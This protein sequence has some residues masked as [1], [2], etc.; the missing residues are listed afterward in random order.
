[1]RHEA[2]AARRTPLPSTR[3]GRR[4]HGSGG[5]EEVLYGRGFRGS[6]RLRAGG[7]GSAS[8]HR[9]VRRRHRGS[10]PF[11]ELRSGGSGD[12]PVR[13]LPFAPDARGHSLRARVPRSAAQR[14]GTRSRRVLP[15][16]GR[17]AGDRSER[18]ASA[19]DTTMRYTLLQ[20]ILGDG[21]ISV[22]FQPIYAM[23]NGT[24]SVFALEALAR[25]PKDSNVESANVLFEYVRRK[26]KEVE[27]DRVCVDAVLTAAAT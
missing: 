6:L 10:A 13:A 11:V 27:V 12:S 21:G 14:A 24:A 23:A 3:R 22:L 16:A 8:R 15:K 1:M 20:Q 17:P 4:D 25:G 26:G 7:G 2:I 5:A 19:G 9:I 18:H